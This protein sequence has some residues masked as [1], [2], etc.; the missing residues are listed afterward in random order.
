MSML[1]VGTT[2]AVVWVNDWRDSGTIHAT[3]IRWIVFDN[4]DRSI[5]VYYVDFPDEWNDVQ[6]AIEDTEYSSSEDWSAVLSSYTASGYISHITLVDGVDSLAITMD[7]PDALDSTSITFG[8]G[9]FTET[10][11]DT[12]DRDVTITILRHQPPTA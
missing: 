2:D 5:D 11:G 4:A 8:I 7:Q 9:F 6:Q 3:E 1:E 12:L 10:G